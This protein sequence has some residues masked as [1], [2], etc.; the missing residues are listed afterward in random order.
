MSLFSLK[1]PQNSVHTASIFIYYPP[2]FCTGSPHLTV[3]WFLTVLQEW[4]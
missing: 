2:D 1:D 4:I 3:F